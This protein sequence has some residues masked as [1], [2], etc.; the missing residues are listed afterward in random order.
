MLGCSK[1]LPAI[2]R[3]DCERNER[4]VRRRSSSGALPPE[5]D[6]LGNGT[7]CSAAAVDAGMALGSD[8]FA[9]TG[10]GLVAVYGTRGARAAT[11]LARAG[12]TYF[13][14]RYAAGLQGTAL[15]TSGRMAGAGAWLLVSNGAQGHHISLSG[16]L[17]DNA[18]IIGAVRALGNAYN[19]C[20][21]QRTMHAPDARLTSRDQARECALDASQAGKFRTDLVQFCLGRHPS[22]IAVRAIVQ[23]QQFGDFVEAETQAL[24]C[25]DEP[26]ARHVGRAIRAQST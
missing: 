11:V 15:R 3:E 26:Y 8:A 13:A 19:T 23:V 24:R 5:R 25:L 22:V 1:D 9:L 17:R 12:A 2:E 20:F 21:N 7:A 18:P 10:A 16:L 4:A 14:D 6:L